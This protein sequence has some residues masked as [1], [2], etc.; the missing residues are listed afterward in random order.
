MVLS[1]TECSR[2]CTLEAEDGSSIPAPALDGSTLCRSCAARIGWKLDD[3]P[4]VASRARTALIPG[5]RAL[6]SERVSVSK[7]LQL[8]LNADAL[9]MCDRLVIMLGNWCTYWAREM[10]VRPPAA[11]EAAARG[12]RDVEGVR[13]GSSPDAVASA[14]HEW[15]L[16]LKMQLPDVIA[17]SSAAAFHDDLCETLDR[18][19]RRFPRDSERVMVGQL[20]PRYCPVCSVANVWVT[21][22]D[23]EP[24]VR[25]M[26]CNW[27]FE[28]EWGEFLEAVGITGRG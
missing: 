19:E 28:T 24:L 15:S 27:E 13:A 10:D 2:G 18:A 11:L 22:P 12:D 6:G 17:H 7:E 25:C 8:P 20:R 9:E 21:W 5:G 4:D 23:A 26:S 14:M 3:L 16:W 1:V